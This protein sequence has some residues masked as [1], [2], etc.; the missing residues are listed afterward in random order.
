[1]TVSNSE[2][3]AFL[4]ERLLDGREVATDEDLLLS[5]LLDSLGVM[6]LVS[7]LETKLDCQISAQDVTIENFTS[8]ET[9]SS[10]LAGMNGSG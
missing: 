1:M 5:G 9:I 4:S 6:T 3:Q 10:F 8:V 2:I 7:Y